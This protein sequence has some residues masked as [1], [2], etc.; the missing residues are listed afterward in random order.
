MSHERR[1]ELTGRGTVGKA[2]VAGV[3]DRTTG[4]VSARVVQGTD[5]VTLQGFVRDHATPGT[6]VYTDEARAYQGM[7]DFD[8]HAVNHSVGEYVRD[9]AHTNGIEGFWSMLKRSIMGIFHKISHKHL[10]RY[11]MEGIYPLTASTSQ[12]HSHILLKALGNLSTNQAQHA[13]IR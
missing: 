10:D 8:H 1:K 12:T 3:K 2:T 5:S 13:K 9:M 7:T 4:Q 11:I 6:T